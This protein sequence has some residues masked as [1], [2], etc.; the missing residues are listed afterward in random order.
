MRCFKARRN[1]A[2]WPSQFVVGLMSIQTRVYKLAFLLEQECK[3]CYHVTLKT[4]CCI[5]YAISLFSKNYIQVY[6]GIFKIQATKWNWLCNPF[7][8]KQYYQNGLLVNSFVF[9]IDIQ[10]TVTIWTTAYVIQCTAFT[11]NNCGNWL[12]DVHHF[13]GLL[14]WGEKMLGL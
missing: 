3:Y 5:S 11:Q 1:N 13:V 14:S 4:I 10:H 8:N 2:Y 12:L 9:Y 7:S 6:S